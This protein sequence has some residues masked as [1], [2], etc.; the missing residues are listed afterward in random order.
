VEETALDQH[1]GTPS[2][3]LGWRDSL[4]IGEADEATTLPKKANC[5][6]EQDTGPVPWKQSPPLFLLMNML[7]LKR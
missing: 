5:F 2:H 4:E 6:N 3:A 7:T 1:A